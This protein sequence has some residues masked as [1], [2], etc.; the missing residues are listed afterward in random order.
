ME[1]DQDKSADE[2]K[3][4]AKMPQASMKAK[5]I[6][7][8]AKPK[9]SQESTSSDPPT[10]PLSAYN[11]FFRDERV[12]WLSERGE[13]GPEKAREL[14]SLMGKEIGLRWKQLSADQRSRYEQMA[15]QDRERYRQDK[16]RHV[17]EIAR[18]VREMVAEQHASA[19]AEQTPQQATDREHIESKPPPQL[20]HQRLPSDQSQAHFPGTVEN[21]Q[22]AP[23]DGD[24]RQL[25]LTNQ[26]DFLGPFLP[27]IEPSA[28]LAALPSVSVNMRIP[29]S[30]PQRDLQQAMSSLQIQ[31]NPINP[32]RLDP[33]L[34]FS[35][36][37]YA[38]RQAE[39]LRLM[40]SH[41]PLEQRQLQDEHTQQNRLH[42]L[43]ID[44]LLQR[45][46]Q[47][48]RQVDTANQSRPTDPFLPQQQPEQQQQQQ[49][50][51]LLSH[52]G[53]SLSAHILRDSDARLYANL[54]LLDDSSARASMSTQERSLLDLV[55]S[56]SQVVDQAQ[57]AL[58]GQGAL[59]IE[60]R[61][62]TE[63]LS[64]YRSSIPRA[65]SSAAAALEEL[66][67]ISTLERQLAAETATP[68]APDQASIEHHL[69]TL[70]NRL[71]PLPSNFLP[72]ALGSEGRNNEALIRALLREQDQHNRELERQR[73]QS[74]LQPRDL[75]RLSVA[76]NLSLQ[77]QLQNHLQQE[78]LGQLQQQLPFDRVGE[79]LVEL[80]R[81]RESLELH[82]R[83]QFPTATAAAPGPSNFAHRETSVYTGSRERISAFP[84]ENY[85]SSARQLLERYQPQRTGEAAARGKEGKSNSEGEYRRGGSR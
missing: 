70:A 23:L 79:S 58:P 42:S 54:S 27:V 80:Q 29:R 72:F 31:L 14:F 8:Q 21:S 38:N 22:V 53:S 32:S 84:I 71:K 7:H 66:E 43:L 5:K 67:L 34:G 77:L 85:L 24:A 37:D 75:E 69:S 82:R 60:A 83:R 18:Q 33:T 1:D 48:Q 13:E 81:S 4:P 65:V 76:P 68:R 47:Q 17:A 40:A 46:S 3:L 62:M 20:P 35:G 15:V 57:T 41:A 45:S 2:R 19:A 10:R 44:E 49:L 63:L 25:M 74:L 56:Q 50:S 30:Q 64:A 9:R 59:S 73:L 12:R 28:T 52:A 51:A 55:L 78:R 26:R 39:T 11:F 61:M 16:K 36:S 6:H